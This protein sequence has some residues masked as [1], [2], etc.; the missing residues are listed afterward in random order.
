MG[1]LTA[2][3]IPVL[4]ALPF[5]CFLLVLNS[6]NMLGRGT[7]HSSFSQLQLG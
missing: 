5:L 6:S 4:V 3:H 2:K 1:T 7:A